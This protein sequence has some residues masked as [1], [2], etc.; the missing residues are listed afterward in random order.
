MLVS[1]PEAQ[2]FFFAAGQL[3][4]R[5]YYARLATSD[6]RLNHGFAGVSR[7]RA[8]Q[9]FAARGVSPRG[10]SLPEEFHRDSRSSFWM[11]SFKILHLQDPASTFHTRKIQPASGISGD[12]SREC[13]KEGRC[14]FAYSPGCNQVL[15]APS[16]PLSV[17]TGPNSR[18]RAT[19]PETR[20][21]PQK[22]R[23]ENPGWLGMG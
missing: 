15:G 7:I 14:C 13:A 11:I 3:V 10:N 21:V 4:L 9:P 20:G 12:S 19:Q 1:R 17:K 8:K 16:G 6:T 22:K 18:G 2:T 5:K 23:R